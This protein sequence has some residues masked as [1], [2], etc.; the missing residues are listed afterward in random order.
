LKIL[1]CTF[2][3]GGY[4]TDWHFDI[5]LVKEYLQI[6]PADI[7]EIG[8]A[9]QNRGPFSRVTDE[10]LEKLN[11]PKPVA[12]MLNVGDVYDGEGA[13]LVRIA[14]HP[15]A[16]TE[17]L[18]MADKYKKVAINMMRANRVPDWMWMPVRYKADIVWFADSY[19]NMTP[20]EVSAIGRKL[21]G[22]TG[23]HAHNNTNRALKNAEAALGCGV[24]WIDTTVMGIG[25]G[26]GNLPIESVTD[27]SMGLPI[28]K[29]WGW[30]MAYHLG[31]IHDIHPTTIQNVD[32]FSP[33]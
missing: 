11:S 2:R 31:A 23:F 27:F 1:D 29:T 8:F 9:G 20:D 12:V 3:D 19:G 32:G 28:K 25:R 14:T 21:M 10:L 5:G 26:A 22:S 7:V 4:Q 33:V 30:N 18:T 16:L 13:D 24:E 6:I 15:G 17:A